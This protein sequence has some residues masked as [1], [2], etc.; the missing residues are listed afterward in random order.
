[1][2]KIKTKDKL[3]LVAQQLFAERGID[4]VSVREIVHAAEQKN[5]ASLHYYFGTKEQLLKE[6]LK[7]AAEAI[8]TKRTVLLDAIEAK[9]GPGSPLEVL[10]IFIECAVIEDDDPRSLS[11][12]RLFLMAARSDPSLVLG[13]VED[14]RKSAYLRCLEHLRQFMSHM[15]ETVVERRLF[16]LQQYVFNVLATRERSLSS[17]DPQQALW[18]NNDMLH[19][20]VKTAHGLLFSEI[21]NK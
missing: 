16:L 18:K 19:E 10:R 8:E 4:G 5:M 15:D 1:M 13:T 20:L 11:N 17:G 2:S 7:D 3:K 12:V 14:T 9:G 6:L 21:T